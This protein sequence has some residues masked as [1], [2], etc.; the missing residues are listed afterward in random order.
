MFAKKPGENE[1]DPDGELFA[2][3]LKQVSRAR[4]GLHSK[5]SGPGDQ[6][7]EGNAPSRDSDDEAREKALR[8]I[9]DFDFKPREICDFLDRYVISQDEAKKVISVAVCDHY[10]HVRLCVED[11]ETAGA[12]YA[13]H[14][15]LLLGPTGVGK[16]YLIR[17]AARLIGVPF[18]KVDATKFS[19]TGYVGYDVEDIVRDLVKSADNNPY[20]ARFGIVYIDEIDKIAGRGEAGFK[21]VSGRGVQVNLLKLMENTEVKLIGQTDMLAQMQAI[22]SLQMSGE[23]PPQTIQ[24]GNILFIVSGAFDGLTE[25]I[26]RR[27]GDRQIGFGSSSD[28]TVEDPGM[29]LRQTETADLIKYGFEPEFVGRLPVRVAFNQLSPE[30]LEEILL[31]AEDSILHQYEADFSGYRIDLEI[32]PEAISEIARLASEENT[33]ARGLMTVFEKLFREFK[34]ELPSTSLTDLTVTRSMVNDPRGALE[35]LFAEN[36]SAVAQAMREQIQAFAGRFSEASGLTIKFNKKATEAIIELGLSQGKTVR[37]ICEEK[38]QDFEYGLKLISRNTGKSGFTIT[39][40]A[41]QEPG[42]TLSK[43]ITR[44]YGR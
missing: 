26:R 1:P 10:N 17:C 9:R 44:S 25:L 18:I 20:L 19:E 32:C 31:K 35:E 42:N 3:F 38:F 8:T 6:P 15:V 13:K 36:H 39:K 28:T 11:P 2:D 30:D 27:L 34:F 5:I 29:I 16:T 12:E 37:A 33:G 22:M 14:N 4:Q 21:D 24:T 23:M 7:K 40:E 41:V 43:W